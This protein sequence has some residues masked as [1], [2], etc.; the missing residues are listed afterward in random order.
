MMVSGPYLAEDGGDGGACVHKGALLADGEAAGDAADGADELRGQ[1]VEVEDER[2]VH[3]VKVGLRHRF[4]PGVIMSLLFSP[5]SSVWL[6]AQGRSSLVDPCRVCR[7][8]EGIW[9]CDHALWLAGA[10]LLQQCWYTTSGH[11]LLVPGGPCQAGRRVCAAHG[12]GWHALGSRTAPHRTLTSAM[13][14]PAAAGPMYTV[15]A[16]DSTTSAALIAV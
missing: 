13:P 7:G 11:H 9:L 12:K 15:T 8:T 16:T 14:E 10:Q 6:S 4:G 3:A 5:Q 2:H 1:R